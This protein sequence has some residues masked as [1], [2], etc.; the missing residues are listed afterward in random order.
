MTTELK[1]YHSRIQKLERE[2][3]S[4]RWK[5]LTECGVI[6]PFDTIGHVKNKKTDKI[7][8]KRSTVKKR[9]YKSL[10]YDF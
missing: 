1:R 10:T 9:K 5:L 6:K 8:K 2:V 7:P 4:L 3:Q